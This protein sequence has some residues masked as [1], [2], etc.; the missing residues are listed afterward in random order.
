MWGFYEGMGWWMA[1][2]GMWMVVFWAIIIGLVI[3]GIKQFAGDRRENPTSG[4]TP[5]EI[6]QKR[7]ARGEITLDEF[8][9]IKIVIGSKSPEES[10]TFHHAS[11]L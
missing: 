9:E 4:E 10:G 8:E 5:L 1:F 3:W 6:A 7:L 11:R 2:G